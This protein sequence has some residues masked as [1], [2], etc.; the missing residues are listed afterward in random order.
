MDA[1][2]LGKLSTILSLLL[3]VYHD[4]C[5]SSLSPLLVLSSRLDCLCFITCVTSS[6]YHLKHGT[7]SESGEGISGVVSIQMY[8]W[9][10]GFLFFLLLPILLTLSYLLPNLPLLY[11]YHSTV[12]NFFTFSPAYLLMIVSEALLYDLVFSCGVSGF[13]FLLS[14]FWVATAKWDCY[15]FEVN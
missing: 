13:F 6:W 15:C 12:F 14:S 9:H 3:K 1:R 10:M 2:L 8:A 11:F 4:V 5:V 7:A